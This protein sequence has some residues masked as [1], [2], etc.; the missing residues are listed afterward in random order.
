[1][2]FKYLLTYLAR[3]RPYKKIIISLTDGVIM[4]VEVKKVH[5]EDSLLKPCFETVSCI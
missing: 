1:M 4:Q 3:K 5:N 2:I